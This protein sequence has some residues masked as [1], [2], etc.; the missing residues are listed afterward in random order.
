MEC[1]GFE[2][3]V[4]EAVEEKFIVIAY[5]KANEEIRP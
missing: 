3:R 5:V 1:G 2:S 4:S